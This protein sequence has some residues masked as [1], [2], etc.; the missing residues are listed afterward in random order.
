M[1][2][3]FRSFKGF[4]CTEGGTGVKTDVC[5]DQWIIEIPDMNGVPLGFAAR[6]IDISQSAAAVKRVI[7]D[8]RCVL[9]DLYAG[10]AGTVPE[11]GLADAGHTVWKVHVG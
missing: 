9:G 8:S 2:P 6:V 11:C 5:I 10:Q 3:V 4:Y 1:D 7:G